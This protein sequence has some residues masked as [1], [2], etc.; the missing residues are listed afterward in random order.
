MNTK[1]TYNY[2]RDAMLARVYATVFP[3]VCPCVTRV[4]GI[5][6]AKHFV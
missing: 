6:T 2:T 3:S 4:L 5:K 1:E